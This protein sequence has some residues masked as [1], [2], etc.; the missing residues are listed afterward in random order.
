[1]CV[2]LD[3]RFEVNT[4]LFDGVIEELFDNFPTAMREAASRYVREGT[5]G[6]KSLT[7]SWGIQEGVFTTLVFKN[8]IFEFIPPL[9]LALKL[10]ATAGLRVY[11]D[12]APWSGDDEAG[13]LEVYYTGRETSTWEVRLVVV[14]R[15][16]GIDEYHY[17]ADTFDKLDFTAARLTVETEEEK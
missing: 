3:Y 16:K 9:L 10:L 8:S 7:G 15:V 2:S 14:H 12:I 13:I 11:G 4:D 6:F 5:P 17:N 1:M